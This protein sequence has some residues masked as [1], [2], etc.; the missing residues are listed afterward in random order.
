MLFYTQLVTFAVYFCNL[1]FYT[2]MKKS[3]TFQFFTVYN[4]TTTTTM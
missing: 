1:T 3:V 2:L 4:K